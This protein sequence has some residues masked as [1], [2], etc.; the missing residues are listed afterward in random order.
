MSVAAG[1]L[2]NYA[3]MQEMIQNA[4]NM[5]TTLIICIRI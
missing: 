4:K 5:R 2:R 3:L 1:E